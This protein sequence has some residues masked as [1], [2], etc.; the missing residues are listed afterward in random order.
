MEVLPTMSAG[1]VAVAAAAPAAPAVVV[2]VWWCVGDYN[3]TLGLY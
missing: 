3:T 2:V 1:V